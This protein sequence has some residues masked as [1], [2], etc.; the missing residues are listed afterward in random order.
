MPQAEATKAAADTEKAAFGTY[1]SGGTGTT[2]T[3]REKKGG[4]YGG[5]RIV[6]E[7]LD[8]AKS[9]TDLLEMRSKKKSDKYC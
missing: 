6:S 5:Y 7:K 4:T 3:Y 1:A 9:R 2:F 8:A